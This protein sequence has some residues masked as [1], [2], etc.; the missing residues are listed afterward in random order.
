MHA[1]MHISMHLEIDI[2]SS[3]TLLSRYANWSSF[4]TALEVT[5][6]EF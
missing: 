1:T 6:N 2:A 3:E 5:V 4:T